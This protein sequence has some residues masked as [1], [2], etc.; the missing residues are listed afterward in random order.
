M[1]FVDTGEFFR[2]KEVNSFKEHTI[3]KA[4]QYFVKENLNQSKEIIDVEEINSNTSQQTNHDNTLNNNDELL[5]NVTKTTNTISHAVSESAVLATGASSSVVLVAG[6]IAITVVASTPSL[7]DFSQFIKKEVGNN[8]SIIEFD[9][10]SIIQESEDLKNQENT[11]YVLEVFDNKNDLA[12]HQDIRP[13]LNKYLIPN[14]E[15]NTQ[16]TYEISYFSITEKTNVSILKDEFITSKDG[17]EKGIINELET[18]I[19]Y[20]DYSSTYSFSYS[21]YLSDYYKNIK[22]PALYISDKIEDYH[23]FSESVYINKNINQDNFFN[24]YIDNINSSN[25]YLYLVD[26]NPDGT[27]LLME[28][29]YQTNIIVQPDEPDEPVKPT[30][31]IDE[32]NILI[33]T[34]PTN[35]SISG[36]IK[37]YQQGV[38]YQAYVT[39]Y[40][41]QLHMISE[42]IEPEFIVNE[43]NSQLDFICNTKAD[44]GTKKFSYTIYHL[45]ENEQII[46]DFESEMID[47]NEN[48]DEYLATFD[49]KGMEEINITFTDHSFSFIID[50][51]YK[52]ENEDY[53]YE[54]LVVNKEN[55]ILDNYLGNSVAYF[56]FTD[57]IDFSYLKLI[58]KEVVLFND[59]YHYLQTYDTN[60]TLLSIPSLLLDQNI[61]FDGYDFTLN[62]QLN[63]LSNYSDAYLDLYIENEVSNYSNSFNN[64]SETGTLTLSSLSELG[65][66]NVRATLY[67]Y[68]KESSTELNRRDFNLG[69]FDFSYNFEITKVEVDAAPIFGEVPSEVGT[70]LYFNHRIPRNYRV[71]VVD[72]EHGIDIENEI[73]DSIYVSG[74]NYEKGANL[75]ITVLDSNGNT[76]KDYGIYEINPQ[77]ANNDYTSPTTSSPNPGD[78]VVTYN[79]DGTVNIYRKTMF[80]KENNPNIEY[81]CLIYSGCSQD[82]TTGEITY[83][84]RIDSYVDNLYSIIE[85][86][87]RLSYILEY[88]TEFLFNNVSYIMYKEMPSGTID[89]NFDS[90]FSF[91]C[92]Q[93][94]D[95]LQ[96]TIT[97]ECSR[98][99]GID[100]YIHINGVD[101]TFDEYIDSS[102]Y[103]FTL[104]LPEYVNVEE[105]TLKVNDYL[106]YFDSISSEITMKGNKYYKLKVVQASA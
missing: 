97:V 99:H 92:V 15:I 91:T 69:Q 83:E 5:K 12:Y 18:S 63:F 36:T 30:F 3:F 31:E 86:V 59:G 13:G 34:D 73:S 71:K 46:N 10:N 28:E 105:I 81:N 6:A 38:Q 14:L 106:S 75:S 103:P 84:N 68:D 74:I 11:D 7:P 20:D 54:V 89:L 4:E 22:N 76:Y 8:Y 70:K 27:T 78:S 42:A 24:G 88:H 65:L 62:Y 2:A 80:V 57:S 58:Y 43:N 94:Q 45:D 87:P 50:P 55:L 51:N 32:A 95:S 9:I 25:L 77:L 82:P 101:Y 23:N 48:Q 35:I 29:I 64:L 49:K 19:F 66:A 16:Y 61:G 79:D 102:M 44:Y 26:E 67:F 72:I 90:S 60:G 1:K 39:T 96:T 98:Y 17:K 104:T 40:D 37:T 41:S 56:E 52:T 100:N 21:V 85:N 53:Y 93:S 47:F 33:N